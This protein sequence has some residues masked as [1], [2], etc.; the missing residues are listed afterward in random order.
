M[1][2]GLL[3]EQFTDQ[4]PHHHHSSMSFEI[5][6]SD[7]PH[8]KKQL[9]HLLVQLELNSDSQHCLN[10]LIH[11][12]IS[13]TYVYRNIPFFQHCAQKMY[14]PDYVG[15]IQQPKD[16]PDFY[17]IIHNGC[18]Q[19]VAV[20]AVSYAAGTYSQTVYSSI[21]IANVFLGIIP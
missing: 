1:H 4:K 10:V 3:N 6:E 16:L 9:S 13:N 21:Y 12:V 7:S 19:P 14:W 5:C 20:V 2:D 8:S 11:P 18:C 15:P 17:M